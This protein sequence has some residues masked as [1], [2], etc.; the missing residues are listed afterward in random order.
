MSCITH[1]LRRVA[2]IAG[3]ARLTQIDEVL[4]TEPSATRA[5]L[6]AATRSSSSWRAA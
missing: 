4:R 2:S 6:G 1:R 3:H 5:L